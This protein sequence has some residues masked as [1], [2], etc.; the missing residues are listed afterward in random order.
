MK[1]KGSGF[2]WGASGSMRKKI[3]WFLY[4]FLFGKKIKLDFFKV[5]LRDIRI[6]D[7]FSFSGSFP[8]FKPVEDPRKNPKFLFEFLIK[9]DLNGHKSEN[10]NGQY[11]YDE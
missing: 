11:A 8:W 5:F 4:E 1:L 3:I 2:G 6:K 10:N 7:F 9:H